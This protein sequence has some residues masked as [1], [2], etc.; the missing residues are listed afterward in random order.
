MRGHNNK[1]VIP[2]Q[3]ARMAGNRHL[4]QALA[5]SGNQRQATPQRPEIAKDDFIGGETHPDGVDRVEESDFDEQAEFAERLM[6][7][8]TYFEI[9]L[10]S[11]KID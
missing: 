11:P 4:R 7:I 3:T 9:W 2:D 10:L 1:E 8:R 6:P 5:H